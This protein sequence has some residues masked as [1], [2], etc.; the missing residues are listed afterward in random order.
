ME[1][2][3]TKYD[4]KVASFQASQA[5]GWLTPPGSNRCGN[6]DRLRLAGAEPSSAISMFRLWRARLHP[7]RERAFRYDFR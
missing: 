6:F 5:P 2:K 1:S 7:R 4:E 3:I